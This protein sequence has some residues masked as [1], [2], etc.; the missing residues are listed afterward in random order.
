MSATPAP[1]ERPWSLR[2]LVLTGAVMAVILGSLGYLA[3]WSWPHLFP[4]PQFIAGAPS[5]CDLRSGPCTAVFG[6]DR[7]I[8]LEMEPK[9]LLAT[10]PL[11]VLID[12]AGLDADE[13]SVEFSGTTM[14]MGV[15]S[16]EILDTGGGSFAGDAMLPVCVRRRMTWRAI[17]TASG[18]DGIHRA[19]FDFE[20]NRPRP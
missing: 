13:V 14:N 16:A 10:Q 4:T 2:H 20:I 15:I 8:R 17:V 6:G 19:S 18:P 7:F 1:I 3:S 12:T 9:A 11:R 5:D